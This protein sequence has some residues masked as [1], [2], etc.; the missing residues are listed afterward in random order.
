[1]GHPLFHP[2]ASL[3]FVVVFYLTAL[4]APAQVVFPIDQ[5]HGQTIE[6]CSGIFTDSSGGDTLA[7]YGPG[8]DFRLTLCSAGPDAPYPGVRFDFFRL[9]Q[10]DF[11]F[12]YD[13]SDATAPLLLQA[14]AEDLSGR[15]IYGSGQCLHFRFTSSEFDPAQPGEVAGRQGWV[16]HID[17]ASLCELFEA[18][19]FPEEIPGLCPFADETLSFS[20]SAGYLPENLDT[21]PAALAYSWTVGDFAHEGQ[22]MSHAFDEPGVYPVHLTVADPATG[23][24]AHA[25]ELVFVATIPTFEGTVVSVDSA[26]AGETFTLAGRANPTVW[27]GFPTSVVEDPPFLTQPAQAYVSSLEF[28]V[29]DPGVEILSAE[30][31]DRVCILV[32][33]TDQ[34]QLRVELQSPDGTSMLLK[35]ASG[36]T[37]NLGEPVVFNGNT[38]GRGY[39]YCFSP[40]PQFGTMEVTTPRFHEYID[41]A[42]NYY[43]NAAYMPPGNYTPQDSFNQLAGSTLNGEWVLR[44]TDQGDGGAGHVFGWSLFFDEAFYPDSL[45]FVPEIVAQQWYRNG[46]AVQGNPAA[47]SLTETGDHFFLFEVT[48]EFGCTHDTTLTVNIRPLPEAE[49]VSE[50]ELPVCEGDSTVFTVLPRNNDGLHWTYQWQANGVDLP[51]RIHDT[52]MVK[53]P[54]TYTV[55]VTDNHTGCT[56]FFDKTFSEQNCDL[57]IP[58]VFTP[59]GDGI[60]DEFEILN[61]E[62]YPNAQIVVF[63]RWGKKVFEHHDYYNNWWDGGNAPDGVYFYVLQYSR[64][65]E[66]RYAEGAVTIIR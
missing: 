18:F 62:H 27:T 32:E 61:L 24:L 53:Q 31:I 49:I 9:G 37:A 21:D 4:S 59:N 35:A 44:V 12:V 10:G 56:D 3:L 29:F 55:V 39:S 5:H 60:N 8:E 19:I 52:L 23:C 33:H 2:G 54:A 17:C 22:Q 47:V 13:G 45:I 11:L 1:M 51:G 65:G 48:D 43:F 46:V 66:T 34:G 26:C 58:N 28:D 15:R 42:G 36:P 16:A 57:T 41:Q 63:N 30:D 6:T 14:T 50:L 25:V 38:P 7:F 64:M 40:L 20:G